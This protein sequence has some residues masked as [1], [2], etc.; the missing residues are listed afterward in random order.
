MS[1]AL[2]TVGT[3]AGVVA[4]AASVAL[5]AGATAFAGAALTTF[6]SPA[7]RV[8]AKATAVLRRGRKA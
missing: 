6:A 8:S 5:T 7:S 1:K 4:F 3:V 2:R